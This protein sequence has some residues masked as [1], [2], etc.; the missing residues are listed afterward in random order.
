MTARLLPD[1]AGFNLCL[2]SPA[3]D[4]STH[5]LAEVAMLLSS[6]L[7]SLGH[8]CV[9]TPNAL[10][11]DRVNI[12]LGY[13]ALPYTPDLA[14]FTYIPYQLEQ[15]HAQTG[16]FNANAAAILSSAAEVWDY[17]PANIAFLAERGIAAKHLPL[18]WHEDLHRFDQAPDKDI[19]LLFYGMMNER[20]MAVLR[21]AHDLGL[22]VEALFG[23]FL[24]ERDEMIARAKVV[25]NMHY[26][27][28]R[29]FEAVRVSYLL[30]NA[31]FVVNEESED[32]PYPRCGL[33][34][35]PAE[36]LAETCKYF[37]DRAEER[38]ALRLRSHLAFKTHYPMTAHLRA[39]L[40]AR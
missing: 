11:P 27:P 20:R 29:I 7:A 28:M 30:N 39:V 31:C 26:Y 3:G 15:L 40:E 16:L 2:V 4:V 25:L 35:A 12:L 21:A 19:D 36:D 14:R 9:F 18:G 5:C 33:I 24:A 34:F 13:Q 10:M 22:K 6:T 37:A 8:D 23:V 1:T 38:E 32:N 17:S